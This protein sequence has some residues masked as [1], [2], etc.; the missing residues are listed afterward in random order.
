MDTGG[1]GGGGWMAYAKKGLKW[2][3]K[4]NS[5]IRPSVRACVRSFIHSLIHSFWGHSSVKGRG[6]ATAAKG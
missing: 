2:G 3:I 4:K 5:L 6:I 1:R